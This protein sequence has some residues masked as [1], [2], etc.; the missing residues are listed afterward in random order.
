MVGSLVMGTILKTTDGGESW[1]HLTSGTNHY[2]YSI[3]FDSE[4]SVGH[5][6]SDNTKIK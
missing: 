5:R 4:N 3:Y 2:L 1:K 6:K